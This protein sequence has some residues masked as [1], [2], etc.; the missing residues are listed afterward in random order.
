MKYQTREI[1][2][3]MTNWAKDED[4]L[5]WDNSGSQIE[6]NEETESV[7]VGMDLTD[8]LVDLAVEK[9]AKL[10]I[11]HHP[12]FFSG[13]KNIIEDTYTGDNIIKLI[14]NNISVFS[15]HTSM[16]VA[17]GGVNYA[18]FD[19]LSLE[20]REVLAYDEEK[21]MGLVGELNH[22]HNLGGLLEGLKDILNLK[23]IRV[24]G[25]N[26]DEINKIALMGGAGVD[27]LDDAIRAGADAFITGDVK[28]HDGQRAYEKGIILIDIGHFHSEKFIISKIKD[29]LEKEFKDLK[30][31]E[32]MKSSYELEF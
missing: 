10:I 3:F 11:T 30:V 26:K 4:Q 32:L 1:K 6:F 21:P 23:N 12:L 29:E 18:L 7:V 13:V 15:Y 8:E 16:D 27:F 28:Y 9:G 14:K 20:N 5:S 24:Y 17:I 25:K 2:N 22:T 19:K 31:Y